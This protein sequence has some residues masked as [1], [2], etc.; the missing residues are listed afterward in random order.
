M[1]EN[2]NVRVLLFGNG[3]LTMRH[4]ILGFIKSSIRLIKVIY[5]PLF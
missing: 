1:D 2:D 4:K 5:E 3:N